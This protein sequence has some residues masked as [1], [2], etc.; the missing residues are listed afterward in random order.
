ML[1]QAAAMSLSRSYLVHCSGPQL[2]LKMCIIF[3]SRQ[4]KIWLFSRVVVTTGQ[5]GQL[6]LPQMPVSNTASCISRYV[7]HDRC[8]SHQ[9]CVPVSPSSEQARS[10][11]GSLPGSPVAVVRT[12]EMARSPCSGPGL[13]VPELIHSAACYHP[14]TP[15]RGRQWGRF[16]PVWH[17][18]QRRRATCRDL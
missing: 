12:V 18:R 17:A 1:L 10:R 8:W 6:R 16:P 14:Q 15:A 3:R 13:G 2:S 4:Q 7:G 5:H 11:G 9:H